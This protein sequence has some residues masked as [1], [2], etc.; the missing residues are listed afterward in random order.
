M[1]LTQN[2]ADDFYAV[3]DFL[4]PVQALYL[5]SE[6]MDVKLLS[7]CL[8]TPADSWGNFA[9]NMTTSGIHNF[10]LRNSPPG[11]V[12]ESGVFLTDRP[13]WLDGAR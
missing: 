10:P 5:T 13:R 3:N 9:F 4:K 1:W 2:A 11:G 6:T 12:I 7:D 8:R